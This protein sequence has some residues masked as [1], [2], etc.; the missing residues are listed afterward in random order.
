MDSSDCKSALASRQP[1]QSSTM[2]FTIFVEN[3]VQN[4]L[5]WPQLTADSGKRQLQAKEIA[6]ILT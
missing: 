1:E 4:L 2:N 5:A 6:L 3:F